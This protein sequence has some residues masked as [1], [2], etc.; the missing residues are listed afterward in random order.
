MLPLTPKKTTSM[1]WKDDTLA[2][3]ALSSHDKSAL[4]ARIRTCFVV[5]EK[6]TDDDL[7]RTIMSY[8]ASPKCPE[9]VAD[10][11]NRSRKLETVI[12]PRGATPTSKPMAKKG[13]ASLDDAT[14]QKPIAQPELAAS[15][16]DIFLLII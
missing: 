13:R 3:Q 4:L 8:I 5:P 15:S 9:K 10:A 11:A 7:F 2:L 1:V 6:K 14:L 16:L 12:G